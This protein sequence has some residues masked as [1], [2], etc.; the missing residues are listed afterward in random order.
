MVGSVLTRSS[1][2]TRGLV[3]AR[4]A[5]ALRANPAP[6][7]RHVFSGVSVVLTVAVTRSV[8]Q[9]RLAVQLRS[10]GPDPGTARRGK[11]F[12]CVQQPGNP[13]QLYRCTPGVGLRISYRAAGPAPAPRYAQLIA[14]RPIRAD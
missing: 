11:C 4:Y 6:E 14:R 13:G 8:W 5:L 12:R 1:S 7:A 3:R 2:I 10:C 9:L